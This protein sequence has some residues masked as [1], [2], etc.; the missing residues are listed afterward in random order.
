MRPFEFL[1]VLVNLFTFLSLSGILPAGRFVSGIPVLAGLL[2]AG[3]Q[4][5]VEGPRWQMAPAAVLSALFLP[6]WIVKYAASV[7]L[8]AETFRLPWL[9][10]LP[11]ALVLVVSV[12]LPLSLPVFQFP[13]PGGPYAVGTVTYHWVDTKR[14]EFFTP[15]PDDRREIMVQVWY[16]A[17]GDGGGRYAPYV[18]EGRLLGPIARLLG[19]PEFFLSHLK[20]ITT[21]AIPFAS[22]ADEQP[23]YPVLIF[24]HGRGGFRQHNT[25][26]VEELVSHGYVVAAIDHPYAASGVLFPDGRTAVFDPRMFDPTSPG[27][28]KIYDLALPY[29][30]QDILFT[31]DQLA[32]VNEN[33]PYGILTGRLDMSR[34]A[35]FGSSLG[36]VLA[37]EAC[38]LDARLQACLAMDVF[39]TPDVAGQG[40]RQPVMWITRDAETMQQEGWKQF[41]IEETQTTIRAAFEHTQADAYLVLAPGMYHTDFSDAR[42]LS[43]LTAWLGLTGP[44]D[45]DLK[46]AVFL[47]LPLAF[48]DR[49]LKGQPVEVLDHLTEEYPGLIIE[50]RSS[51]GW[52]LSS[53]AEGVNSPQGADR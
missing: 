14:S 3:V 12:V 23:Q 2:V 50:R 46:D 49:H 35:A 16:P 42:F 6:V 8:T 26:Q 7:R 52:F 21:N 36:G 25:R 5:L 19:L 51:G 18:E 30:T 40:L 39:M 15:D 13:T 32:V 20:Y 45:D 31:L 33:D 53:E 38:R 24:S 17:A 1:L 28:P 4:A 11:V 44:V 43:P 10:V 27:H 9:V 34:T 37:A 22:V 48:F 41:D 47:D 29:L